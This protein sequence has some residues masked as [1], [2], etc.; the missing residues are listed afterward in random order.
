MPRD[1]SGQSYTYEA[2]HEQAHVQQV[3]GDGFRLDHAGPQPAGRR[4][5]RRPTTRSSPT[6]TTRSGR[7]TSPRLTR[8]PTASGQHVLPGQG[9]SAVVDRRILVQGHADLRVR[10]GRSGRRA[11][12]ALVDQSSPSRWRTA[13]QN[14]G[15]ANHTTNLRASKQFRFRKTMTLNVDFDTFN[16]FNAGTPTAITLRHRRELGQ[17]HR[18]DGCAYRPHRRALRLLARRRARTSR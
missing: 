13:F 4:W 17:G 12:P 6:A 14:Q 3:A 9:V 1:R 11:E 8:R 10:A 2:G 16:M 18:E 7:P 15:K 5:F